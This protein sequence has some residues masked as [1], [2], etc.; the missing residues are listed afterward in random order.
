[1][2]H[3]L[4]VWGA[5]ALFFLVVVA[6]V[7][8]QQWWWLVLPPALLFYIWT[9]E[10][11]AVLFYL[12]IAAI[13]WSVE[14]QF[15]PALGTDFPDEPLMWANALT[16]VLLIVYKHKAIRQRLGT[17]P[18]LLLLG[19]QLLWAAGSIFTSTAPLLSFKYVLAK[20]WYLLAFVLL[21]L[22]LIDTKSKLKTTALVLL[23]S[24]MVQV[25]IGVARHAAAGFTFAS[26][27]E[28][29]APFFRNHVNYSA[30]LVCILPLPLLCLRFTRTRSKRIGLWLLF[31]IGVAALCL[32]YARGAWVAAITGAVAYGLLKKK[33]LVIAFLIA[34]LLVLT[35]VLWLRHNDRYLQYAHNYHKT[36][37]HTDFREHLVA[38]YRLQDM[39]TAERFYRWVAGV[40]MVKD[41]WLTGFGP[42]TFYN[43][44]HSYTV[45]LF[46]TWV[47]ANK[48]RSTVH[49]YFLLLLIEQ[50]VPGLLLFL[51][52][53]FVA[54]ATAQR[55]YHATDDLFWKASVAVVA[56]I[57]VMI[58]TLNFLSDLIETDKVGPVFY[59]C[60]AVLMLAERHVKN[61]PLQ[62]APHVQRIA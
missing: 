29:V 33:A 24:M 46:K 17:H 15:T 26:I 49:N 34:I 18:L 47:S 3:R 9:F 37:F 45:P 57:L 39:S 54:F 19:L 11:P 14:Y 42:N 61:R 4:F 23:A 8:L 21:P 35:A 16:A 12:L 13:P 6:A 20:S 36:I 40:R 10:K 28:S 31:G 50:G 5:T 53:L 2:Q 56:V 7:V 43:N 41:G 44:Y 30:L 38:T 52:V 55:V 48:E 22:L 62:L 51:L 59:L 25:L 27:N 32:S 1:M 60:L 58:C